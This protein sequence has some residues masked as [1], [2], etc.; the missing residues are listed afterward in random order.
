M[1]GLTGL[2]QRDMEEKHTGQE[3][4]GEMGKESIHFRPHIT[5]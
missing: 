5:S 2:T 4:K 3:K 1:E